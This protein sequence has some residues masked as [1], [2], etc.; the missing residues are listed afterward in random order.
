MRN[1]LKRLQTAD[2]KPTLR[3]RLAS[4]KAK[5]AGFAAETSQG[6]RAM[7]AGCMAAAMP[8]PALSA[9]GQVASDGR[10]DYLARL[11]TAYAED[12][13]CRPIA[14]LAENGSI[15]EAA[16][17]LVMRRCWALCMEILDLPAPQAPDGLALT[18]L[19]ATIE[20]EVCLDNSTSRRARAGVALTRA[21]LAVT[22]MALPS[23][24]VGF[25]DEPDCPDLDEALYG[26]KGSLPAWAIAEAKAGKAAKGSGT[27]DGDYDEG[28]A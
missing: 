12:R 2:P 26:A 5:P 13:A 18:A 16:A 8:L 17:D 15:E 23:G 11:L 3:D 9:S 25:G 4:M 21:V 1:P 24:F 28:D 10:G 19:A 20:L 27:A 6:R 7:L 22:G 14:G